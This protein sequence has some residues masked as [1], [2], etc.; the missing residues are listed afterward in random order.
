MNTGENTI[1]SPAACRLKGLLLSALLG[2]GISLL[3]GCG[4]TVVPPPSPKDPVPVFLLD[5]GRHASLVLPAG[6]NM[7]RYAYGDWE[8]YVRRHTGPTQGSRAL[9]GPSPAGLGRKVLPGPA[10]VDSV[11]REVVVPIEEI[12]TLEAGA[13]QVAS[14][15]QHLEELFTGNGKTL[16]YAPEFDLEF[17]RHPV[18]Y[19]LRHN[20][21]TVVA[22]WLL[23][24]GFD[25]TGDGPLSQ[26]EVKDRP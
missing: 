12:F 8:W 2:L 26:W 14:L 15:T 13:Q 3:S 24:L 25:I 11:R 4:Y 23:Q 17:V 22:K 7:V 5:H 6:E 21:N 1:R 9:F 18:P 16:R 19:T 10:A 20:S